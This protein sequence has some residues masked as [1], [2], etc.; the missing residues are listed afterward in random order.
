MA[1][2]T[3]RDDWLQNAMGQALSGGSVYYCSQPA[4]TSSLPPSPLATVYTDSTGATT[5]TQPV[6]TDGFG[7]AVAYLVEGVYTVVY[8]APT[9]GTIVLVDQVAVGPYNTTTVESNCDTSAAGTL[10]GTINGTN[11]VFTLSAVPTPATSL[12]FYI[13]GIFQIPGVDYTV[14]G[15][16]I[17]CTTAPHSGNELAA[18]Y[19]IS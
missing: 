18:V 12:L 14:S 2:I 11:T 19:Q 17:T 16:I 1:T 4:N 9:I 3:R 5:V 6:V 8:V 13:G 10:T 15:Q 7:H